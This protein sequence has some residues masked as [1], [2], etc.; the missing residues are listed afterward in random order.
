MPAERPVEK[1]EVDR[2]AGLLNQTS[3]PTL[4]V[5]KA[6]FFKAKNCYAMDTHVVRISSYLVS[7]PLPP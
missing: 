5:Q 2:Q 7:P 3:G 1:S 4:C 6:D